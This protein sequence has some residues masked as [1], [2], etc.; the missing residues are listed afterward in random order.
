MKRT[1]IILVILALLSGLGIYEEILVMDTTSNLSHYTQ[2]L[3]LSIDNAGDNLDQ[4]YV[5]GKFDNLNEFWTGKRSVLCMFTNYD[6]LRFMD[7]SLQKL[8]DGIKK[9]KID[10]VEESLSSIRSFNDFVS[11]IL[12]FNINN[13]F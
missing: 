13:L 8:N 1:I 10:M 3:S 11:Y 5:I 12:G 2:E 9:N 7:E 6:K 4:D